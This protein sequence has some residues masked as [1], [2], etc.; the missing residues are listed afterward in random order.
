MADDSSISTSTPIGHNT[1]SD[2]SP[3]YLNPS[4]N[5]GAFITSV[6]LTGENYHE[7]STELWNSLQ[8]KEN[9]GFID[10]TIQKQVANPDLARWLA[11]NSMIFRTSIDP[12]SLIYRY[13]C[14]RNSKTL[15]NPTLPLFCQRRCSCASTTG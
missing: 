1:S 15:R 4:D 10:C 5:P 12:K 7:W 14:S 8:S 3:Y 11:T 2:L 9:I 6:L 13:L